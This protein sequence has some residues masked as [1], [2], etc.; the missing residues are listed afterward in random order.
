MSPSLGVIGY[1][2]SND[3]IT[4]LKIPQDGPGGAALAQGAPGEFDSAGLTTP[5]VFLEGDTWSMY[6]AGFDATGQFS[7]GLA[8]A[9]SR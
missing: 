9:A 1:A 8:R 7:A 3:G 4:W 2:E 5:S 6:Y